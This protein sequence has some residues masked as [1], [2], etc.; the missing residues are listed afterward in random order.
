MVVT[1]WSSLA[2]LPG[3]CYGEDRLPENGGCRREVSPGQSHT[4]T[5]P[6]PQCGGYQKPENR[7]ARYVW[8]CYAARAS[9]QVSTHQ[10]GAASGRGRT[11]QEGMGA[12]R[13]PEI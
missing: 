13:F 6:I 5:P 2:K 1:G 4:Y 7:C 8:F 10:R 3:T 9:V 12:A 11:P